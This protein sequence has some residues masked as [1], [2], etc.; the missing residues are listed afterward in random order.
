MAGATTFVVMSYIIFVNPLILTGVTHPP[1][2]QPLAFGAVLTNTC[3]VAG[4]ISIVMGRASCSSRS[5]SS[6]R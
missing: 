3:L 6:R 4:V 1:L 2:G 5:C